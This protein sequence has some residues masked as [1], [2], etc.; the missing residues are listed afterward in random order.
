MLGK[1]RTYSDQLII[2]GIQKGGVEREKFIHYLFDTHQGFLHKVRKKQFLSIEEAQD[3]YADAVVKLASQISLGKFRGDSKLSTYFYTIF[4]NKCVDVS[5]KKASHTSTTIEE[6]PELSDPAANILH[7]MDVADEARQVR[8]VM[9]SMGATCKE[10]LLDWAYMGYS[11]EEI[12]QRRNL[13]TADSAR[14][15]K[16]KCLKKLRELLLVNKRN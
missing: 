7:K 11:M 4:Y 9:D 15:L 16:Y 14:S 12:A 5:R 10:I 1:K 3:A 13:K 6:Y 8:G 2:E